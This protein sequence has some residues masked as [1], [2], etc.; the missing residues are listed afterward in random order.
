MWCGKTP[1]GMKS[2]S[3]EN[4][5]RATQGL[6]AQTHQKIRSEAQHGDAYA[7]ESTKRE[8]GQCQSHESW[9]NGI[10][11]KRLARRNYISNSLNRLFK[12]SSS[13]SCRRCTPADCSGPQS[14]NDLDTRISHC[15][16]LHNPGQSQNQ[17]SLTNIY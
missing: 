8:L 15:T 2:S 16:Y 13:F 3:R 7:N 5:R 17:T 14:D 12:S 9:I 11:M 1:G 10:A 4:E 6:I